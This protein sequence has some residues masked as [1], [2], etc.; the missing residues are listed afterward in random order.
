MTPLPPVLSVRDLVKRYRNGTLANDHVCLDLFPGEVFA[1]LGPNGAGKT[2]L[3][4]QLL[5]LARPTSGSITLDGVD[6]VADPGFARRN[7]GFLPQGSFDLQSLTV[8][9]TIE[10]AARLRGVPPREAR[11]AAA[12]LVE[13]LDLGPFRNTA[14]HAASGGVRRLAGFAAAVAAPARLLVLD[15][16][17][18]DVDPLRRAV[19]WDLI[20][21]LG[22]GGATILLVTHN[23]AEAERVIDRLA[24]MNAGRIIREGSPAALRGLVTERLRLEVTAAR[25]L[26]PHP[27]LAP[28]GPS[29]CLFDAAD[30][31]AVA[32]WLARLRA[33][34]DVL[35]FRI[36][37][38]TLEDIYAAAMA[39]AGP[40]RSAP[41]PAGAR[42]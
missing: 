16:P 39:P 21:E 33:A 12:R 10:F 25:P 29:A 41:L 26:A 28:D 22:R 27:A 14:M 18:N 4:R 5:G 9:E 36:G 17:T 38:P 6:I 42:A 32:A 1:L 34:G 7:I 37:P 2:T 20:A 8:A 3:V 19:L 31:P 13:R 15:E 35:D 11:A 24:I 30:L 23:L 40:G